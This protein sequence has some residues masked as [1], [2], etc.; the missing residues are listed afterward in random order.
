MVQVAPTGKISFL[1]RSK[2]LRPEGFVEIESHD[3]GKT[4]QLKKEA[5][6]VPGA[7]ARPGLMPCP[8]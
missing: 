4:W 6:P 5:A 3:H 1:A 2:S 7:P 8:D